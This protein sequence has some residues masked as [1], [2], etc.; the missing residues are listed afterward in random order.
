KTRDSMDGGAQ[1]SCHPSLRPLPPGDQKHYWF[2]VDCVR[3]S[4]LGG[5]A[6]GPM[7]ARLSS[8]ATSLIRGECG[9]LS[10]QLAK[11]PLRLRR[12][13]LII[14]FCSVPRAIVPH[15]NQ[16]E[17]RAKKKSPGF[18]DTFSAELTDISVDVPHRYGANPTMTDV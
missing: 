5:N 2:I 12:L 18:V 16:S 11:R 4:G 6:R 10:Q 13:A 8:T 7:F 15:N 9:A 14:R 1:F 17:F 3:A